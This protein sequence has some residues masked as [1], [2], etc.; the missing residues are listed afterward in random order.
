M[1]TVQGLASIG[2]DVSVNPECSGEDF[3][4]LLVDEGYAL[5]SDIPELVLRAMAEQE[6]VRRTDRKKPLTVMNTISGF[7]LIYYSCAGC[8]RRTAFGSCPPLFFRPCS[9]G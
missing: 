9:R 8:N 4:D 7:C 6:G 2:I 5:V 1:A 3:C